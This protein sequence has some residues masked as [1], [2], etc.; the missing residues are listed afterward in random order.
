MD[1]RD[2]NHYL[3]TLRRLAMKHPNIAWK[4]YFSALL[5]S[6]TIITD[7]EFVVVHRHCNL[8]GLEKLFIERPKR[9]IA[10][11]MLWRVVDHSILYLNEQVRNRYYALTDSSDDQEPRWKMCVSQVVQSLPISTRALNAK[12]YFPREEKEAAVEMTSNIKT[13]FKNNIKKVIKKSW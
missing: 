5:P 9:V 3:T 8:Y 7:D 10:N 13:A 6:N 12:I 11:Y 2:R 1:N 4:E